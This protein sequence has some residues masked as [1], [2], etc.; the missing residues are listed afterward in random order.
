LE[1][2]AASHRRATPRV[3]SRPR[4]SRWPVAAAGAA[5]AGSARSRH[6]RSMSA[7]PAD[8]GSSSKSDLPPTPASTRHPTN[9]RRQCSAVSARSTGADGLGVQHHSGAWCIRRAGHGRPR[10]RNARRHCN[11]FPRSS[12][13]S[14]RTGQTANARRKSAVRGGFRC[15]CA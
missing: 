2:E 6:T 4:R 9:A 15:M 11:T 5:E 13:S 10:S 12:A 7:G 1:L 14:R 3:R 8:R